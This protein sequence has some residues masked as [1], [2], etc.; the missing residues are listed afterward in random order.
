MQARQVVS[1][2]SG[3][4]ADSSCLSGQVLPEV[5]YLRSRDHHEDRP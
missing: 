5:L 2:L 1:H 3:A 4:F